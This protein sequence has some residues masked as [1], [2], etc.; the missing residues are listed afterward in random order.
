MGDDR[1]AFYKQSHANNLQTTRHW[2]FESYKPHSTYK[3]KLV[4]PSWSNHHVYVD[5]I[6]YWDPT[7]IYFL[8]KISK[9]EKHPHL[10]PQIK[11]FIIFEIFYHIKFSTIN[12]L[13]HN[14]SQSLSHKIKYT[15]NSYKYILNYTSIYFHARIV[16]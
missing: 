15:N 4:G 2:H 9:Y 12:Y 7:L 11:L 16:N 1:P 8:N 5:V 14:F 10:F 3:T 13:T 6:S